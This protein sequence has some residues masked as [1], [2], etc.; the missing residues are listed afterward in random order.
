MTISA[1][2]YRRHLT[3]LSKIRGLIIF[4][5]THCSGVSRQIGTPV[6]DWAAAV[7]KRRTCPLTLT[8]SRG[9]Q[10]TRLRIILNWWT[11]KDFSAVVGNGNDSREMKDSLKYRDEIVSENRRGLACDAFAAELEALAIK[12]T[13]ILQA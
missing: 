2:E 12:P 8:G 7:G 4:V 13:K 5:A 11:R 9:G 1:Y 10:V 6:A 3:E